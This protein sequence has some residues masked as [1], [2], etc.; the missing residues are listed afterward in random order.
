MTV[1]YPSEGFVFLVTYGRSGSTLLQTV[2]QSID[3][4][5]IRGENNNVLLPI[6]RAYKRIHTARYKHGL[7][8]KEPIRPWYGSDEF[9]PATFG[10]KLTGLFLEE[11]IRA[12]RGQRVVGFK[13]IRFHEADEDFEGLL[14]F[15]NRFMAPAKFI[16]NKRN[17]EDVAKS[18]WWATMD[19]DKVRNIVETCDGL[20]RAYQD[21]HPDQCI[22]LQYEDYK[23]RPEALRPLFDF[24]GED[25]DL[26]KLEAVLGRHLPHS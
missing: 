13:E 21:A 2:L 26:D 10:E 4:Y 11:V 12:P 19:P 7:K 24:L 20:Y 23:G 22:T 8:E 9:S 3:G 15:M 5:F 18:A 25:F 14:D 16:F 6:Y 17:W 1:H